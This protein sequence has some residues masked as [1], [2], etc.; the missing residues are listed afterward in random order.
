MIRKVGI[1]TLLATF[2]VGG[3]AAATGQYKTIKVYMEKVSLRLN[4]QTSATPIDVL[5]Y[6]GTIY[7]PI[8]NVGQQLGGEVTWD[9]INRS[10]YIDFAKAKATGPIAAASMAL[11]QYML[12]EKNQVME[13]FVELIQK[14]NYKDMTAQIERLTELDNLA[15]SIGEFDLADLAA[16]M[17]F[18]AEVIRSGLET[19][20]GTDY[21]IAVKLFL[22]TEADYT[23]YLG[24]LLG[25]VSTSSNK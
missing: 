2:L 14:K 8:R 18:S 7:I 20:K 6:N 12:I 25:N 24:G 17:A 1:L 13:Q 9:H 15:R 21:E 19:K 3:Y 5:S 11:Y 10:V 16:Q 4:G 23:S 22:Q